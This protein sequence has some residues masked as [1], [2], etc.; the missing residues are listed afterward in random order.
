MAQRAGKKAASL[1]V[2]DGTYRVVVLRNP[3]PAH[4]DDTIHAHCLELAL[5]GRGTDVAAALADLAETMEDSITQ[6]YEQSLPEYVPNIDPELERVFDRETDEFEGCPVLRRGRMRISLERTVAG[7]RMKL[8]PRE[9]SFQPEFAV[10]A[11]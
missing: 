3:E 11:A 5:G 2:H 1:V 7:K 6:E 10:G 8:R 4:A 9:F